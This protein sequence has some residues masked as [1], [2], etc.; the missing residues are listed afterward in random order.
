[1]PDR[2]LS[3]NTEPRWRRFGHDFVPLPLQGA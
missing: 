1:M 2:D 3:G